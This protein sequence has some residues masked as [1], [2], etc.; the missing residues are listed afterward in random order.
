MTLTEI[1]NEIENSG[2]A[3]KSLTVEQSG[4]ILLEKYWGETD[5]KELQKIYSCTKSISSLLVGIA[6]DKNPL[7]RPETLLCE[8]VPE[9][10]LQERAKLWT[11]QHFLS[12]TTG[13]KWNETGRPFAAG[14]SGFDMEQSANW[15]EYLLSQPVTTDPGTRFNYNTGVSH[16][17][18]MLAG[19]IAQR[20]P[21]ELFEEFLV[22]P[23]DLGGYEW[24]RDPQGNPTGGKGLSVQ[25]SALRKIGR[26]ILNGGRIEK[27]NGSLQIVS[28]EWLAASFTTQ[29]RGH[30]YYGTY[31]Y[32]WWL[33]NWPEGPA[34]KEGEHNIWCGI[35]FGGQFLFMVPQWDLIVV[36]TGK[37][38]GPQNFE[39][40]QQVFREKILPAFAE[41]A[42]GM[43]RERL[44]F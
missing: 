4:R 24:D 30:I 36:F 2:Y 39:Y 19:R 1:A 11:L 21:I 27:D 32:Q 22:K 41:R 42:Q 7:V 25:P 35:G 6:L 8:I 16:F 17:L 26:M 28:K 15:L 3:V 5:P 37:L 9:W 29:S 40:P 10:N 34:V 43:A 33:K 38:I 14:H 44:L 13:I 31:G 23:L 20:D 18:P 12:Q